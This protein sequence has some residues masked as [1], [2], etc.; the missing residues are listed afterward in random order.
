MYEVSVMT[1]KTIKKVLV[2]VG[3]LLVVC[4]FGFFKGPG[5]VVARADSNYTYNVYLES[6]NDPN[7]KM[8]GDGGAISLPDSKVKGV[9]YNDFL[10]TVYTSVF[11]SPYTIYDVINTCFAYSNNVID[12]QTALSKL[13]EMYKDADRNPYSDAESLDAGVKQY[14]AKFPDASIDMQ[15][16]QEE[17]N[18]TITPEPATDPSTGDDYYAVPDFTVHV[19]D[20]NYQMTIKYV[21]PDGTAAHA[22]NVVTGYAGETAATITSPTVDKYVPDQR[23]VRVDFAKEGKYT[24][25]VH[26]V[27]AG[28]Q[29]GMATGSTDQSSLTAN[30]SATV[31]M[32]QP[33]DA[34]TFNA[35][36][37]DRSGHT[38][39]VT[40]DSSKTNLQK[41]GVYSVV[42]KA[43][44]GKTKTVT[45]IVK[46]DGVAAVVAPKK[47][48]IYA[49]KTLYLYQKPTFDK[50]Q[51]V[52]KYAKTTRTNRPMFVVTG[53][54]HSKS[55]LLRYKV[56]DV[57]H[58][59]KT[60]G[61][62]G[63]VTARKAFVQSVYYQK[64]VKQIK[65][66]SKQG[67]NLYKNINLT[68]PAKHVKQ[69]K[70]LN[71]VGLKKHNLTTRFVLSN[72]QYLTANK[73]L[74]VAIK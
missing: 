60:A 14:F 63:Y 13:A 47:S 11:K 30:D 38:I 10:G 54:G 7:N 36:A 55:G 6:E 32:G 41:P 61:K 16:T 28:S 46:A 5:S 71:I 18:N 9:S 2:G 15:A 62:T 37:T 68:K 17:A 8:W 3:F 70:V 1:R 74:V 23:S 56:K 27:K 51:R 21:L 25:T 12:Q 67:V 31:K 39:P 53:Y 73:K 52:T 72:G 57:N 48:A 22:D 24:T 4:T 20:N 58:A 64:S 42:L 29:T 19:I 44:N 66:L 65:V 69:G 59:S 49:L 50:K 35:T 40:V 33:V 26:Y 45:L 43:E 34:A